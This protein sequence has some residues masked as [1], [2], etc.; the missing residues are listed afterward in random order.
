MFI[1][2]GAQWGKPWITSP[3]PSSLAF[4]HV[5]V[6]ASN[7]NLDAEENIAGNTIL[8]VLNFTKGEKIVD[9]HSVLY[10]DR[11]IVI[12]ALSLYVLFNCVSIGFDDDI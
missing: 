12:L 10:L 3:P 6:S 9:R 7:N 5:N 8:A 2:L 11:I 4:G 1:K